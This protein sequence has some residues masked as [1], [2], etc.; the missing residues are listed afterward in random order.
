MKTLPHA[1][2]HVPA[3]LSLP[4]HG[5][6][7]LGPYEEASD[8]AA[9]YT[10]AVVDSSV[11]VE[12]L[13]RA[14]AG[15]ATGVALKGCRTGAD[16]QHLA[17]LLSVAEAEEG[18]PEGAISILAMTDGILPAP[19]SPESL[20]GKSGRLAAVVW[21]HKALA[22]TLVTNRPFTERGE[23]TIAFAAARAA[24]LLTAA[25]AGVPAYDSISNLAETAFTIDCER[26]R[27]EG[28]FGR[29]ATDRAQAS[30]IDTI[31]RRGAPSDGD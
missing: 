19:L 14:L 25:A 7:S 27:N 2:L 12:T 4:G 21:D 10:Y 9:S 16:L 6:G 3:G 22:Q 5:H 11:R 13:R 1:L 24:A 26:S 31:Y 17:T 30:V 8:S 23:W 29:L 28:F 15:G 18:L 20:A